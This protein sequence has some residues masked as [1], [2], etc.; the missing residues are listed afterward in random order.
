MDGRGR[1]PPVY[2]PVT[3]DGIRDAGSAIGTFVALV[4]G[5]AA[6]GAVIVL[7]TVGSGDVAL[8]VG[9]LTLPVAFGLGFAAWRSLVAAWLFTHLGR[10]ALRSGGTEDGFRQGMVRSLGALRNDGV[11]SLPFGWVFVPIAILV[12]IVGA[13]VI[14]LI[15]GFEQPMGPA[16]LAG[17]ATAYGFVLRRLAR[18]GRLLIPGE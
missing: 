15:D 11:P 13:I 10:A 6:I 18:S 8:A 9:G 5:G 12:G 1:C 3:M 4:V 17:A 2:A 16:L 14:G 7:I